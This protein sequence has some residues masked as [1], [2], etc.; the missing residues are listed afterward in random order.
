MGEIIYFILFYF[1]FYFGLIILFYFF[2]CKSHPSRV[3]LL[4]L[5]DRSLG[6]TVASEEELV[7]LASPGA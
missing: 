6:R 4:R 7:S 1:I 5:G 2:F 3:G